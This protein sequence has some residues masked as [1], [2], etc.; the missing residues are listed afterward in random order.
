MRL[1]ACTRCRLLARALAF[2]LAVLPVF[3]PAWAETSSISLT[4]PAWMLRAD[5]PLKRDQPYDGAVPVQLPG[6]FF[7]PPREIPETPRSWPPAANVVEVDQILSHLQVEADF[8][9][10]VV[11]Q[12]EAYYMDCVLALVSI[13]GGPIGGRR[14][15]VLDR[16]A[17]GAWRR[18]DAALAEPMIDALA[19]AWD[20]SGWITVVPT[21]L[22]EDTIN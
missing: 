7:D 16:D 6:V 19:A 9:A 11:I 15:L 13:D 4:A 3:A 8:G 2:C 22:R 5:N 10:R 12:A 18:D 20:E 21:D 1:T 14:V 17:T